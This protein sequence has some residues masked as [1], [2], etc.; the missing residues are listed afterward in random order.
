MGKGIPQAHHAMDFPAIILR[1]PR[2]LI[3]FLLVD[4]RRIE[5]DRSGAQPL[6]HSRR[7]NERLE[8]G[9]ALTARLHGPIVLATSEIIASDHRPNGA[10]ARFQG[11]QPS[12]DEG[13]LFEL[14]LDDA[15]LQLFHLHLNHVTGLQHLLEIRIDD[16]ILRRIR[17]RKTAFC[18]GHVIKGE[19][20]YRRGDLYEEMV[21]PHFGDDSLSIVSY[22]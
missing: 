13:S 14:Y 3:L 12:L 2:F 1:L 18:P 19:I 11:D 6:T 10:L 22:L 7:V 4:N 16:E 21:F 20:G 9:S 8:G 17:P 15:T 5:N